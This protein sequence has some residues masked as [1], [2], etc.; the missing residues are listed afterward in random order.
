MK[1][2]PLACSDGANALPKMHLTNNT[3]KYT[4]GG[5]IENTFVGFSS[6]CGMG[7]APSKLPWHPSVNNNTLDFKSL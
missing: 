5:F 2:H 1:N 7:R 4:L 6:V 3:L